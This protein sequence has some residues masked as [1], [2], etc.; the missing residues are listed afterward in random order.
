MGVERLGKLQYYDAH[1]NGGLGEFAFAFRPAVESRAPFFVVFVICFALAD[2][3][4]CVYCY[5]Y[6]G[7]EP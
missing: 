7:R 5:A 6:K 1:A 2:A 4:V 3:R